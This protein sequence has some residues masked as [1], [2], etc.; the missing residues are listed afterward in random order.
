MAPGGQGNKPDELADCSMTLREGVAELATTDT[1]PSPP[2]TAYVPV[3]A[4]ADTLLLQTLL[5][6]AI[7][8]KKI[9]HKCKHL[10]KLHTFTLVTEIT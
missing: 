6:D 7:N 3:S 2:L 1:P 9:E 10:I 4:V 8:T 5:P